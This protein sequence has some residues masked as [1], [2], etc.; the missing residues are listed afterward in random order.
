MS[1]ALAEAEAEAQQIANQEALLEA[2]DQTEE[3]GEQKFIEI[4][5]DRE[6]EFLQESSDID[7]GEQVLRSK[8]VEIAEQ[9]VATTSSLETLAQSEEKKEEKKE[10]GK[11]GGNATNSTVD[12]KVMRKAVVKNVWKMGAEG[13]GHAPDPLPVC[14]EEEIKAKEEEEKKI[15][16][17]KEK[18]IKDGTW[19]EP[20]TP[21]IKKKPKCKKADPAAAAD[22]AAPADAAAAPADAAAAPAALT[23]QK[24]ADVP[25]ALAQSKDD[26]L[27]VE[28]VNPKEEH[29]ND[30]YNAFSGHLRLDGKR[31]TDWKPEVKEKPPVPED[32]PHRRDITA[33]YA[34]EYD[35]KNAKKAA[36]KKVSP[37][38]EDAKKTAAPEEAAP[39]K[40]AEAAPAA[41]AKPAEAAP[42]T[43]AAPAL[44]QK[45]KDQK[46]K[47]DGKG[48]EDGVKVEKPV[49]PKVQHKEDIREAFTGHIRGDNNNK[50]AGPIPEKPKETQP[51]T[52]GQ[53]EARNTISGDLDKN[54]KSVLKLTDQ[55]SNKTDDQTKSKNATKTAAKPSA[56]PT[57]AVKPAAK[58]EAKPVAKPSAAKPSAAKTSAPENKTNGTNAT[59][60][61]AKVKVATFASHPAKPAEESKQVDSEMI[62]SSG[63]QSAM[64]ESLV[65]KN[66]A[67]KDDDLKVEK[68]DPVKDHKEDIREAFSGHIK[69]NI[70]KTAGPIP[71]KPKE[72]PVPTAQQLD[73]KAAFGADLDKNGKNVLK[74]LVEKNV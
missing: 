17:L 4:V 7:Q 12:P 71:E 66:K 73:T 70:S 15:E 14:T 54:G 63:P 62:I 29:K 26:D 74:S 22:G 23:Q 33:A 40:S 56:K 42:A 34:G 50:T 37:T 39:A 44:A 21:L 8:Q 53:I 55:K 35:A 11:D 36:V 9:M 38:A 6:K 30:V 64:V 45:K 1:R 51:P 20:E 28:K 5:T 43:P 67:K 32:T 46:K 31:V 58:L 47:E 69:V 60:V 18:Q 61:A 24:S 13:F 65:Q 16:E 3:E 52:A 57:V 2:D 68:V 41:P 59:L 27:K 19:K 10:E 49:N 25:K 72:T 48:D